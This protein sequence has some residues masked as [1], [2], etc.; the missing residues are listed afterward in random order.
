MAEQKQTAAGRRIK[1]RYDFQKAERIERTVND[2]TE[3]ANKRLVP[4]MEAL[5]LEVTK[6]SVLRYANNSDLMRSDYIEKEKAAAKLDNAYLVGMVEDNARKKFKELFD[7]EPYDDRR[8]NYPDMMKLSRGRLTADSKAIEEAA[9][10][11]VED[12]A[13]LEAYD[14]HQAAVK[15][16]NEF[17]QGKAPEGAISLLNYFPIVD[18]VVTPG[19]TMVSYK[20]FI[21][22]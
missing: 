2:F 9:T 6:E 7:Q 5:G 3:F 19:T 4:L 8:T 20:Q 14:R 13:E 11:Y 16:L 22:H 12:P 1:L 18:G 15:A 10:V 17:F 21:K